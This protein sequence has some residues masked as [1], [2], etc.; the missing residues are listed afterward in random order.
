M[1]TEKMSGD[2]VKALATDPDK[3][4]RICVFRNT[5]I[6]MLR[7]RGPSAPLEKRLSHEWMESIRKEEMMNEDQ[8]FSFGAFWL[9]PRSMAR[10]RLRFGSE[11]YARGL[12]QRIKWLLDWV[13]GCVATYGAPFVLLS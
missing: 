1:I 6:S 8:L 3:C 11:I 9:E 5:T 7:E 10:T 2:A 4:E 13:D 12:D